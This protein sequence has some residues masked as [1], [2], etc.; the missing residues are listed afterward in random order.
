MR[1]AGTGESHGR[2]TA[3]SCL[4]VILTIK[5]SGTLSDAPASNLGQ[6]GGAVLW[7]A[8]A[9]CRLESVEP[10]RNPFIDRR[11]AMRRITYLLLVTAALGPL[12]VASFALARN[13]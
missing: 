6:V 2:R 3:M 1:T 4:R 9:E 13:V 12:C 5:N 7:R 10:S 8:P 11:L